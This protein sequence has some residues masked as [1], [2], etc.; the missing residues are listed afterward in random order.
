[1]QTAALIFDL[2]TLQTHLTGCEL[3]GP[4]RDVQVSGFDIDSRRLQAGQAFVAI[5][6]PNFDGHNFVEQVGQSDAVVAVVDHPVDCD[7]PQLVVPDTRL[8]LGELAQVW[9]DAWVAG[10]GKIAALTGSN[11]KTSTK[12]MLAAILAECGQTTATVG[13][14]NNDF[15]VPLTLGRIQ[16]ADQF[17]VIEMGANHAGEIEYLTRMVNPQVGLITNAG[18]AHLEGFGSLDGVAQAKGEIYCE[19]QSDAIAVVNGNDKYIE[20]WQ[21][22]IGQRAWVRFGLAD[23][24]IDAQDKQLSVFAIHDQV[25]ADVEIMQTQFTLHAQVDE[26]AGSAGTFDVADIQLP[27]LGEHNVM[28]ALAAAATAMAL[29]ATLHQVQAGLNGVAPVAGRLSVQVGPFNSRLIDDSYN[30]NP[31]SVRA[32]IDVLVNMPGEAW[33]VFGDMSEIGGDVAAVHRDVGEYAQQAGVQRLWCWGEFSNETVQAFGADAYHFMNKND[34][35][36]DLFD[37]LRKAPDI[38]GKPNILV[39]GSRSSA[40][41]SVIQELQTLREQDEV[42]TKC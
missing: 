21:A 26:A 39:K 22:M 4:A 19:L 16:S 11:G 9:R 12:E 2:E 30:A 15:G 32:G 17:A 34:L 23:S 20:T 40:M 38:S 5:R 35:A 3:V 33:L 7:L 31:S 42:E 27:R 14:L 29:G 24:L 13:N 25:M 10:G 36:A 6:G 41:E 8:A 1:M 18:A 37:A 28:N